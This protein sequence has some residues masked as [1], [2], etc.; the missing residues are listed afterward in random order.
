[1]FCSERAVAAVPPPQTVEQ[2][3]SLVRG[4]AFQGVGADSDDGDDDAECFSRPPAKPTGG[5]TNSL[6]PAAAKPTGG[7]GRNSFMPMKPAGGGR[8]AAKQTG[9]GDRTK[10]LAPSKPAAVT[11]IPAKSGGCGGS[12]GKWTDLFG[13]CQA[14]TKERAQ[15]NR[16]RPIDCDAPPVLDLTKPRVHPTESQRSLAPI[17]AKGGSSR[18][19]PLPPKGKGR[20]KSVVVK[21]QPVDCVVRGRDGLN[22]FVDASGNRTPCDT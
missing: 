22:Y 9:G 20:K 2:I 17:F 10:S 3:R 1:M 5:R 4:T 12:A 14:L 6:A 18:A 7:G 13:M 16:S 19:A 21:E 11:L 8:P 15:R